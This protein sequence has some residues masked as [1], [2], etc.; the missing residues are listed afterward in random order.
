MSPSTPRHHNNPAKC[1][2]DF[3]QLEIAIFRLLE[4]KITPL[5]K[6]KVKWFLLLLTNSRLTVL[7][8]SSC[9]LCVS[10][11][12]EASSTAIAIAYRP[13]Y[14]LQTCYHP[15]PNVSIPRLLESR[16]FAVIVQEYVFTFFKSK[17]RLFTFFEV[18]FQKREKT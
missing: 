15:S 1:Q 6:S 12:S 8:T 17:T 13:P 5:V 10:W 18:A 11:R 3:W 9:V 7:I 16:S 14:L 4:V 2:V